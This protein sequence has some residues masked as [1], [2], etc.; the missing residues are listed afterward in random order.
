MWAIFELSFD[1]EG[2]PTFTSI[3]VN[4]DDR[5]RPKMNNIVTLKSAL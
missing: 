4:G 3:P 5:A 2:I 1:D